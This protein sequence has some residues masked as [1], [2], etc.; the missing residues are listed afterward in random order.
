MVSYVRSKEIHVFMILYSLFSTLELE[1]W[2]HV[3]I[4]MHLFRWLTLACPWLQL[5]GIETHVGMNNS[6]V[7]ARW[8]QNGSSSVYISTMPAMEH[9]RQRRVPWCMLTR[10]WRSRGGGKPGT[11]THNRGHQRTYHPVHGAG[12]PGQP[13]AVSLTRP[14]RMIYCQPDRLV[15]YGCGDPRIEY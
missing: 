10:Q 2:N 13:R 6:V 8:S 1:C 4:C 7:S 5:G 9:H 15:Y 11:G 14:W 12:G 3:S